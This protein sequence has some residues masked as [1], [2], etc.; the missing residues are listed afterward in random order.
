MLGVKSQLVADHNYTA[1]YT[2]YSFA[3][4]QS[5]PNKQILRYQTRIVMSY[6]YNA[7][8]IYISIWQMEII[9][10][11][12]LITHKAHSF[13]TKTSTS[14]CMIKLLRYINCTSY[15]TVQFM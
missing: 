12:Y 6:K 10:L 7:I 15:N 8:I 14:A 4:E 9:V 5:L 11:R 13:E 2:D 1:V 3:S